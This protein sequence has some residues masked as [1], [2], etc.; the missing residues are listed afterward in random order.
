MIQLARLEFQH[1]GRLVI[2]QIEGEIDMSNA[3]DL[4]TAL[5]GSLSNHSAGLVIDLTGVG[6]LDSAAVHVIYELRAQLGNRGIELRLAVPPQA[7]IM[8]ALRLSGVPG[9]VPI[10][11]TAAEAQASIG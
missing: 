10:L 9:A 6:Y 8:T 4:R 7:P 5:L 3:P 1:R 11:A 2:A